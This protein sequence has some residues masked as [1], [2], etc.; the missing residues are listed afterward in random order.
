[1]GF[2]CD[3]CEAQEASVFC[4]SDNAVM[5]EQCDV[6]YGAWACRPRDVSMFRQSGFA[7]LPKAFAGVM[8]R[9]TGGTTRRWAARV[10]CR[11]RGF[12]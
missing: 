10:W 7:T 5:C 12:C 1:M 9:M 4:F 6:R 3:I 2:R 11:R 8:Q